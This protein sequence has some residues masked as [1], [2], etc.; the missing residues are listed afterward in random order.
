MNKSQM[1]MEIDLNK[2][3]EDMSTNKILSSINSD[4]DDNDSDQLN[5]GKSISDDTLLFQ[6]Y[7]DIS[8]EISLQHFV[9]NN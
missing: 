6:S 1:T 8:M 3:N 2:M 7:Q 9:N 4:N 5:L